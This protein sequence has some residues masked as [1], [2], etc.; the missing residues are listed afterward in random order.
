MNGKPLNDPIPD[1]LVDPATGDVVSP[2]ANGPSALLDTFSITKP[3]VEGD[4]LVHLQAP[5]KAMPGAV[6]PFDIRVSNHSRYPLNGVQI[7]LTLP[8]GTAF[9]G[10]SGDSVTL[11]GREVVVTIGRL[12]VGG[13]ASV[14]LYAIL[15]GDLHEGTNLRAQALVRSSTALSVISNE[16]NSHVSIQDRGNDHDN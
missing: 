16:T 6:V 5:E 11:L 8:N 15:A 3:D 14:E 10:S 9:A 1:T 4:L 7:V 13:E 12:D 2:A